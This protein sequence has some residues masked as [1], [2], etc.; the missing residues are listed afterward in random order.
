[1]VRLL[2]YAG[3]SALLVA[4]VSANYTV[5]SEYE[6]D[7]CTETES[8][9]AT[10]VP[11]PTGSSSSAGGYP[12]IT[13]SSS[14]GYPAVSS[15]PASSSTSSEEDDCPPEETS[16]IYPTQSESVSVPV[17]P[18]ESESAS[19]PTGSESAS[20]PVYPAGTPS[21]PAATYPVE[22]SAESAP[23]YPAETPSQP[24]LLVKPSATQPR[25]LLLRT[26]HPRPSLPPAPPSLD[27]V[28]PVLSLHLPR[29]AW[30]SSKSPDSYNEVMRYTD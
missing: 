1:M 14:A 23:T 13:P 9:G 4:T 6:E 18:T 15:Y 2:K 8:Y 19:Y 26:Q 17:Y 5:A 24:V 22:S 29:S 3:A 12:V 10:T 16:S 30:A 11:Y 20:Y 21:Q 28:S 7:D 25:H 27:L